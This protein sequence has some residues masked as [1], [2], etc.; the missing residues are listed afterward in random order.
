MQGRTGGGGNRVMG[1]DNVGETEHVARGCRDDRRGWR[2]DRRDNGGER[3]WQEDAWE[4][5]CRYR[6][7][8]RE[9]AEERTHRGG[10][11]ERGQVHNGER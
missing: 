8:G 2:D 6:Q 5:G 3:K 1:R 4:T 7:W 11:R 10:D 9:L